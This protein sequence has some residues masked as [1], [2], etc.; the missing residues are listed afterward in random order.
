MHFGIIS[1]PVSGHIHPFGALGRE[2]IARGHRVTFVNMS[3]VEA[4]ARAEGLEFARIGEESHPAGSLAES[5]RELGRRRGL[6]ALRFTIQA[7]RGTTEMVCEE[8]P[9]AIERAGIET[10]LVDQTEP[11]GGSV[12]EHLGMPFVTICNAL[13]LNREAGVPPPFTPWCYGTGWVRRARNALGYR[14][15]ESIMSPV[16]DVVARFR[17]RQGLP[18]HRNPEDSFSTLAQISQMP[19]ALDFPRRELP[20]AFH[21]TGPL[22]GRHGDGSE[23]PWE[24]L[25][26]RPLIYASLG[27]LQH[28]QKGIFQCFAE[29]C[30][31]LD[32]Q[33]VLAH[34]G[35][36]DVAGI[37][38]LAGD[39]IAVHYA[40]QREVISKSKIVLTHAGLNTVLDA[41]SFGVP[42]MAVPITYEQPAIAARVRWSGAGRSLPSGELT[43]ARLRENLS[44]LLK[45]PAYARNAALMADSVQCA[46]GTRRAADIIERVCRSDN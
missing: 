21:Y 10:L 12:A 30:A 34:C 15:Y 41:L 23:F 31:G 37:H 28:S 4:Q 45:D 27:T 46:G 3:D 44:L 33:L 6:A 1:P 19:K 8:A 11:A 18:R 17:K 42:V 36:L 32:A 2:L 24:R 35:G 14:V 16:T 25:N 29:A 26:G 9:L 5:L 20:S 7:I 38:S 22:R 39:P 40:P 13:P 43:A